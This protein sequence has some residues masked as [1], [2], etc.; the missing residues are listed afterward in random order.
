MMGRHMLSRSRLAHTWLLLAVVATGCQ[1]VAG[2]DDRYL[3]DAPAQAAGGAGQ[4]GAGG[5]GLAGTGGA[6][7]AGAGGAGAGG[8]PAPASNLSP[9]ARPEGLPEPS[10]AGVSRTFA[11]R[12]IHFGAYNPK[13]GSVNKNY[14]KAIGFDFDGRCTFKGADAACAPPDKIKPVEDGNDCRDNSLGAL[15][16]GFDTEMPSSSALSLEK[17]TNARFEEGGITLLLQI[18]NVDSDGPD[19]TYAPGAL[20][21]A[22]KSKTPPLWDGS[23]VRAAEA[24]SLRSGQLGLP[25]LRFPRGYIRDHT[26]VSGDFGERS[27]GRALIPVS[28]LQ[29]SNLQQDLLIDVHFE[30]AA[31]TLT[32]DETHAIPRGSMLGLVLPKAAQHDAL[33]AIFA[34]FVECT[35]EMGF[36][37]LSGFAKTTPDLTLAGASFQAPMAPCDAI[38]AGFEM[39][40]APAKPPTEVTSTLPDYACGACVLGARRCGAAGAPEV[41][42]LASPTSERPVWKTLAPCSAAEPECIEGVCARTADVAGGA[43]HACAVLASSSSD[44]D[45]RILCWG[46]GEY[47]QTGLGIRHPIHR[48]VSLDIPGKGKQIST[49]KDHTCVL[50][51]DGAVHCWGANLYE[52][53]GSGGQFHS[54]MP[55]PVPLDGPARRV[56]VGGNHTCALMQSGQVRCWGSNQFGQL[57]SDLAEKSSAVPQTVL[58]PS[59]APLDSVAHLALGTNHTCALQTDGK[60]FCWGPRQKGCWG[61]I[62]SDGLEINRTPVPVGEF[63]G[64]K[65]LAAGEW[66]TFLWLDSGASLGQGRNDDFGLALPEQGKIYSDWTPLQLDKVSLITRGD[67][68][69]SCGSLLAGGL[70]CWGRNF[71]YQLGQPSLAQGG[72]DAYPPITHLSFPTFAPP[73]LTTGGR[74]GCAIDASG[75][76]VCWGENNEGQLGRG[77][78][79]EHELQTAPIQW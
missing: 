58:A 43:N 7:G 51:D 50:L 20:Y 76:L 71:D 32:L 27:P 9:P 63:P 66:V 12:A 59:K 4:A 14:W 72:N 10:A 52:Q 33:R 62:D 15:L 69:F 25:L 28:I 47:L 13:D 75:K 22:A 56:V 29:N 45:G 44:L 67:G 68:T 41:C 42:E 49:H 57:G 5:A 61:C 6:S 74:F 60:M 79:S 18:D 37:L 1:W 31:L 8:A 39:D 2:F 54:S 30:S 78:A 26:W 16:S 24:S 55:A 64:T 73:L 53:V 40:W 65:G 23:D 77:F 46:D 19:D 38:S 70:K 34:G 36:G 3:A 35:S 21:L 48:P 17:I 11:A